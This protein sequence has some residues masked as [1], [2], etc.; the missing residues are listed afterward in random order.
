MVILPLLLSLLRG[1]LFGAGF[2]SV[3]SDRLY[4]V[5]IFRKEN[6]RWFEVIVQVSGSMDRGHGVDYLPGRRPQLL[7]REVARRNRS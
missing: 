7:G 6:F 2:E 4:F 1:A 5:L 3:Q